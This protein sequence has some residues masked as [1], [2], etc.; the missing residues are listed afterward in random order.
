MVNTILPHLVPKLYVSDDHLSSRIWHSIVFLFLLFYLNIKD[1]EG[2]NIH[3]DMK[4]TT[5]V[6]YVNKEGRENKHYDIGIFVGVIILD[7]I[8]DAA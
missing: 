4:K 5:M 3:R 6:I 8:G 7:H 1:I 2:D